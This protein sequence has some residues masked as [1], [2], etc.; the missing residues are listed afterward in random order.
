MSNKTIHDVTFFAECLP[1][2]SEEPVNIEKCVSGQPIQRTWHHHTS[3]DGK[4]FAGIWEAE[5]GCWN[6]SYTEDEFC[7][8]LSGQSILRDSDGNEHPMQAGDNLTIPAGFVGQWEV[9]ETTKKIYVIYEPS[10]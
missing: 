9:V 4:F 1:E 5:P 10:A 6:I 3:V 2:F 8:I 7:Q